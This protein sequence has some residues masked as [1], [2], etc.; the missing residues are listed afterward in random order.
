MPWTLVQM[1]SVLE[2]VR[3][4]GR[5]WIDACGQSEGSRLRC[6]VFLK[7]ALAGQVAA[8]ADLIPPQSAPKSD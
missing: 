2:S 6:R 3:N 1:C 7:R 5:T 8:S 4:R